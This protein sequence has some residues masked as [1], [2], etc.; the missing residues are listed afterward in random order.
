M[1]NLYKRSIDRDNCA[2]PFNRVFTT[3]YSCYFDE[4]MGMGILGWKYKKVYLDQLE[5]KMIQ[6]P[7]WKRLEFGSYVSNKSYIFHWENGR[8]FR[9]NVDSSG[10]I[11]ESLSELYKGEEILLL[12]MQ[13]R[14]LEIEFDAWDREKS[15]DFWVYPNFFTDI[16]PEG[17]L[18][19]DNDKAIYAEKIRK[20][21]KKKK[22]ENFKE[23]GIIRYIPHFF[24]TRN[25]RKYTQLKKGY[26]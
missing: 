18:Y 24:R 2:Y 7:D 19:T 14:N 26:F 6:D 5:E 12:H 15:N 3:H 8:L 17:R 21:D 22:W 4:F 1:R 16:K 20:S 9:I 10:K 11:A 23:N 13:K 25:I